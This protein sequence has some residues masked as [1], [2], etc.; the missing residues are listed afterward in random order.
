MND[1]LDGT[2]KASHIAYDFAYSDGLKWNKYDDMFYRMN[3]VFRKK[4]QN[5]DGGNR[6]KQKEDS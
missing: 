3:D 4:K 5:T 1:T 2:W 6:E